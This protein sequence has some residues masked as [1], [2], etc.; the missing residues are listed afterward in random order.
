MGKR[1]VLLKSSLGVCIRNMSILLFVEGGEWVRIIFIEHR[2]LLEH[3]DR[4]GGVE[5]DIRGEGIVY[6]PASGHRRGAAAVN[7]AIHF[8]GLGCI[9][10][11]RRIGLRI[12]ADSTLRR[13][14]VLLLGHE[15]R[16]KELD[17]DP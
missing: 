13:P 15:G 9:L 17:D 14:G 2:S 8:R 5:E 12:R 6:L 7:R 3:P 10:I 4:V 1:L 11:V 16:G